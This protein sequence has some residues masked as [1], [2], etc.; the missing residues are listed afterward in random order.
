MKR[1]LT[2]FIEWLAVT[3]HRAKFRALE[4]HMKDS[5]SSD[6]ETTTIH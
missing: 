6:D 1:M 5:S 3:W 2:R 4:D